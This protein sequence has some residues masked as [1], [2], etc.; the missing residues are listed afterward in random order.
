MNWFASI[1]TAT[2]GEL[3]ALDDKT[4]RMSAAKAWGQAAVAMVSAW[5][6]A[7]RLVRGQEKVAPGANAISAV[8]ALLEKLALAGCSVTADAL[9]CQGKTDEAIVRKAAA[10]VIA[11]KGNQQML[12]SAI[13]AAFAPAHATKF[14]ARAHD[15][16]QT[17]ET[18]HGRWERRTSL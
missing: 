17:E 4:L 9:Q 3:A 13:R 5:A 2:Q 15:S 12:H 18:H 1:Q 7:N 6:S 10:S 8:P 11:V 16:Y 14:A